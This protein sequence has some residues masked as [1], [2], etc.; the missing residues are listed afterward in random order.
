MKALLIL[1]SFIVVSCAHAANLEEKL[2]H[3]WSLYS[4]AQKALLTQV[5]KT[6]LPPTERSI[7]R[8]DWEKILAPKTEF[9]FT[10]Q[11]FKDLKQSQKQRIEAAYQKALK[12]SV[13]N[14][15]KVRSQK[16]AKAFCADL[17]KGG[18]LHIHAG[19][20]LDQQTV[21]D[22]LKTQ[23]T[24]LQIPVLL[25][26][27]ENPNSGAILY[28]D[29][30]VWL[31]NHQNVATYLALTPIDQQSF[32]Q[33]YMLPPGKHPFP[34]FE[35]IFAFL[36]LIAT[37]VSDYEKIFLDFAKRAHE[38]K[39]IYIEFREV[40]YSSFEPILKKIEKDYGIITNVNHAFIRTMSVDTLAQKTQ[41]FL[42]KPIPSWVVGIDLLANED[43]NSALD[44]GQLPYG[45]VLFS[46]QVGKIK[47][48]RRTM[49]AG[50]IGDIRNVRDAIIM[51]VERLG[52]GVNLAKDPVTLEYAARH[53][54]P[55]EVNLSSNLQLT[56]VQDIAT[57][58][59]LDFLRLGLRVSL[60]TDDEGIFNTDINHECELAI[61]Q[62][63][64]TY[65]ELKQ[66]SINS[67]E[68]SFASNT[69]K[70]KLRTKLDKSLTEFEKRWGK[71][72]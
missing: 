15:D 35:A 25:Q 5:Q 18:L 58:P 61:N 64:V 45:G 50:E 36:S 19:G 62:S 54:I 27:F 26:H 24:T 51:G 41:D 3:Q 65:A 29:E 12:D 68:T 70:K 10:E 55:V 40:I 57:H 67:I 20:T 34:R 72:N 14:L 69:D 43:G 7:S 49:H 48:L 42:T 44:K 33:F 71:F 31:R 38:Q 8:D 63:D 47:T 30:M 13:I 32:A 6:S 56:D 21:H 60:S 59:F 1:L 39:V 22:L 11:N 2:Q 4:E 28:A 66:M 52:H 17:P 9:A 37:N 16:Q 53:E 46:N 23:N